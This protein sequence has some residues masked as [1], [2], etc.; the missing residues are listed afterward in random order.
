[1]P[2]IGPTTN[3]ISP[4]VVAKSTF[5]SD[6][7]A[8]SPPV[9]CLIRLGRMGIISPNDTEVISALAKMKPKAACRCGR[10]TA[11][12]GSLMIFPLGRP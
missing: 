1:M 12:I 8:V 9:N 11:G 5:H 7:A 6:A 10:P 3:C 2:R 4:Q